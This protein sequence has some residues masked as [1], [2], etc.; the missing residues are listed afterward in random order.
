MNSFTLEN[1]FYGYDHGPETRL[2]TQPLY[3]EIGSSLALCFNDYR[4]CIAAIQSEMIHS[5][6]WLKPIKLKEITGTPA[7]ELVAQEMKEKK[8]LKKKAEYIR[9]YH[10]RMA[11]ERGNG[12]SIAPLPSTEARTSAKN[13]LTRRNTMAIKNAAG[14]KSV[15][16]SADPSKKQTKE[17]IDTTV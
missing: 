3:R 12:V 10:S 4:Q 6:G 5:K 13:N 8:M 1:S 2:Y 16:L 9:K 17:S 15:L 7:A 11:K 14:E